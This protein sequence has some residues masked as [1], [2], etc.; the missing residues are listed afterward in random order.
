MRLAWLTDV[1]LNF[2]SHD[3]RQRLYESIWDASADAVLIGG[4]IAEAPSALARLR[5]MDLFLR[6]PIYFVLG[7]HDFYRGSIQ[8]V[9]GQ[10]AR[11]TREDH[12]LIWLTNSGVIGLDSETALIGHDSWA[13]GRLGNYSASPVLLNDYVLIQEFAAAGSD[14]A[15]RLRILNRLGDEAAAAV[16]RVLRLAC[17]G[18][19]KVI[20]LTHV[21]PFREACWHQGAISDDNWLPHFTCKAVG[22]VLVRVMSEYPEKQLLVLCGHT[23]SQGTAQIG[24]N[25]FVKTGVAAYG[26]PMIQ[27]VIEVK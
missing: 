14:K 24:S 19:S 13:D 7:N 15:A 1:H 4:D 26:T 17:A 9:R 5:E 25:I 6:L 23:H 16:E 18:Y 8:A 2:A 3:A 22:D 21:P 12:R 10:F 20:L 27:E 11:L